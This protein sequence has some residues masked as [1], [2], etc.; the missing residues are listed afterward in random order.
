[1]K[2]SS[3]VLLLAV[4]GCATGPGRA[5]RPRIADVNVTGGRG[6][7]W[8][9][10]DDDSLWGPNAQLSRRSDGTWSGELGGKVIDARLDHDALVIGRDLRVDVLP[11][12]DGYLLTYR[13]VDKE[14]VVT[15]APGDEACADRASRPAAIA[16]CKPYGCAEVTY[17]YVYG[18]PSHTPTAQLALA[19]LPTHAHF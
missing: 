15:C 10:F 7:A 9:S 14:L 12:E 13:G 5:E 18:R 16:F 11:V 17:A 8:V 1:M 3:A 4:V 6:V 2:S 19:L